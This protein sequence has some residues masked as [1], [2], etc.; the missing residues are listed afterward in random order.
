MRYRI[1]SWHDYQHYKDRCPPWIK[2][3]NSLLTSEVWVMGNDATRALAIASMLLA[4]RNSDNDGT[5]NGDP[6]YVKRFGYLNSKPDFKPLIE[7]GFIE[8]VQDASKMLDQCNTETEKRRAESVAL[9]LPD[10]L[11]ESSI[12]D[13]KSHRVKLKKPMTDKAIQLLIGELT[14]LKS[15]GYDPIECLNTAMLRGWQTPY[16][17]K[18]KPK[19]QP[20]SMDNFMRQVNGQ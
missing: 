2:L 3:H 10:W 20:F 18:D 9:S 5:F 14:K 16:P 1:K 12:Q 19:N 7:L 4:S 17:P 15:D 8:V 11:P 13:F 6:E